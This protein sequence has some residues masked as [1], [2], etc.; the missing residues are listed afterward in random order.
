MVRRDKPCRGQRIAGGA[1]CFNGCGLG[2][3]RPLIAPLQGVVL[4]DMTAP[5]PRL[6]WFQFRLRSLLIIVALV[7]F[8]CSW[9]AVRIQKVKRQMETI[10]AIE[11]LGGLVL[12]P[13]PSGPVWGLALS[14]INAVDDIEHVDLTGTQMTDADLRDLDGL[15]HL[16]S[17]WLGGTSI[18]DEG[19]GHLM[20]MRELNELDLDAT[21]VSDAGIENLQR[22]LP[23]CTISKNGR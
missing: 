21:F 8:A 9:L 17:L 7:A 12:P 4:T 2:E 6:R 19:M 14:G 22:A 3:P 1:A 20:G 5:K 10:A 23:N 15:S 18:T 16:H 11:K 13:A